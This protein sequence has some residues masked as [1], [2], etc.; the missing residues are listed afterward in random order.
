MFTE[1]I[2]TAIGALTLLAYA[3]LVYGI[4]R[5]VKEFEDCTPLSV[6][7]VDQGKQ[8]AAALKFASVTLAF[9][10]LTYLC[11]L[12]GTRV[13]AFIVYLEGL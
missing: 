8:I 12:L 9:F 10:V 7:T 11:F 1:F 6:L 5:L 4:D 3:V 2:N 13:R